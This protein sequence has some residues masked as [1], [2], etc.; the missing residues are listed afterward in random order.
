MWAAPASSHR[1]R[2]GTGAP[3]AP[4]AVAIASAWVAPVDYVPEEGP[5]DEP[6]EVMRVLVVAG[7][8]LARMGLASLVAAMPDGRVVGEVPYD[9][10]LPD[11]I[12]RLDPD[13]VVWDLGQTGVVPDQA[14]LGDTA[15]PILVLAPREFPAFPLAGT[16]AGG[17]LLRDTDAST[18]A[19]ALRA[20]ARGL[21][22][23]DPAFTS[24]APV[25]DRTVVELPEALT[26][27]EVEVLQ[28]LA[29]GLPNKLIAERLGISE[30]TVRFHLN[31]IFGKLD[32][33]TRTEA[34]SRAAHL[35]LIVL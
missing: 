18:L 7:D 16:P 33:H 1:I 15:P 32:A 3:P 22:V 34:V 5:P 35:G 19:A 14:N 13:A 29:A 4:A 24:V 9:A 21:I 11:A 10:E 28:W 23:L 8:P 17:V 12:E 25:R 2:P 6:S 26:P 27:R 30:H 31:A 20:V